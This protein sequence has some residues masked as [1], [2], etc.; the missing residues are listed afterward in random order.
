M[1]AE[2][3]LLDAVARTLAREPG[4]S[5][6]QIAAASGVSRT[7]L[8]RAF[9]DRDTLVERASAHV[10]AQ[11]EELFD[12]AG[13]DDAPVPDAFDRLLDAALPFG[14]ACALLFS[15]PVVYRVPLLVER[16]RAQDERLARFLGRGQ[17]DGVFRPDLPP[18]WLAFSV[19][20]QLEAAWWAVEEGHV[21]G[22]GAPRLLRATILDGLAG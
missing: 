20:A 11:I 17:T 9:G 14:R 22:R 3:A 13:I 4:A 19:T 16:I 2:P 15:E 21:G 12:A 6:Q 10:L 7:T 5:M 8:H 1:P 18:R